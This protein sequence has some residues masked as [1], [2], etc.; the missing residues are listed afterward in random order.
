MAWC[1]SADVEARAGA[2]YDDLLPP[3]DDGSFTTTLIAE[4][5]AYIAA[6]LK[7]RYD[8]DGTT[9]PGDEVLQG[10]CADEAF[11]RLVV[12]RASG[13]VIEGDPVNALK[14]QIEDQ[15]DMIAS[16]RMVLSVAQSDRGASQLRTDNRLIIRGPRG[17]R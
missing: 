17:W 2:R 7:P 15:L 10:L 8:L 14:K 1:A 13:D 11:Y 6:R 12:Y 9:D 4:A 5:G 3:G 16:G